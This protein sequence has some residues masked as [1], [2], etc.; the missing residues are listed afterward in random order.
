MQPKPT[1]DEV[2]ELLREFTAL[3]L[4]KSIS[5]DSQLERDLGITGDDGDALLSFIENRYLFP[6][7]PPGGTINDAF[8]IQMDQWLFHSEGL[9]FLTHDDNIVPITVTQLHKVILARL[10]RA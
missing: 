10:Y 9:P 4:R 6:F 7:A 8:G 3:P 2:I 1:I 5:S